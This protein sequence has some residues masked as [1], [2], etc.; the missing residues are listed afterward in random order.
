MTAGMSII[1]GKEEGGRK[2]G[3]HAKAGDKGRNWNVEGTLR[4]R[5]ISSRKKKQTV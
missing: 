5:T 3:K 4:L 2:P 1:V